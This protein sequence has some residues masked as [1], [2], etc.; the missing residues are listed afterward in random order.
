MK[1]KKEILIPI[2]TVLA[3]FFTIQAQM[4]QFGHYANPYRFFTVYSS[5]C[6]DNV[7]LTILQ[8]T[9][10][11]LSDE[12]KKALHI[13]RKQTVTNFF[14]QIIGSINAES[15]SHQIISTPWNIVWHAWALGTRQAQVTITAGLLGC[16]GVLKE[17][18]SIGINELRGLSVHI[19]DQC[20]S[21]NNGQFLP[22]PG[23]QILTFFPTAHYQEKTAFGM[24]LLIN[25]NQTTKNSLQTVLLSLERLFSPH[26][27][28]IEKFS[29]IASI[30]LFVAEGAPVSLATLN[31]PILRG[32]IRPE[33]I[34]ISVN[35]E[36]IDA[37]N[38]AIHF[39]QSDEDRLAIASFVIN[40]ITTFNIFH[41]IELQTSETLLTRAHVI[42]DQINHS[43]HPK[44]L[45]AKPEIKPK[46]AKAHHHTA[47]PL[48]RQ[49]PA[50]PAGK[51]IL[52]KDSRRRAVAFHQELD[53]A[54]QLS[55]AELESLK[56]QPDSTNVDFD[57]Q[58]D[59][60]LVEA[61]RQSELDQ[62]PKPSG[63]A[64]TMAPSTQKKSVP[65]SNESENFLSLGLSE[66]QF[67]SFQEY[68]ISILISTPNID[69]YDESFMNDLVTTLQ[70]SDLYQ[71]KLPK[72]SLKRRLLW[73]LEEL[74]KSLE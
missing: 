45:I 33:S 30:L 17:Q 49:K 38:D 74:K 42:M 70:K 9:E 31:A 13:N 32:G 21:P 5:L 55:L 65:K 36:A 11:K 69:I 53:E 7:P 26:N 46:T 43:D 56:K 34:R 58:E 67:E 52:K 62:R 66:E 47:G 61:L 28:E 18:S 24:T 60:E 63:A 4:P 71:S 3:I 2:L 35:H 22:E 57:L 54:I 44:K 40:M 59:L 15:R 73:L 25:D 1:I 10:E 68:L 29:C 20:Y 41:L 72:I 50:E 51:D 64:P 12:F 14:I 37:L 19:H 39:I 6:L 8:D 48:R 27:S 16:N 23:R